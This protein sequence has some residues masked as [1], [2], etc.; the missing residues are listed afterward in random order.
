M[1]L[2]GTRDGKFIVKKLNVQDKI[3]V[4][5][6][7]PKTVAYS[8]GAI[9]TGE[10]VNANGTAAYDN[11]SIL[12]Q[13]PYAMRLLVTPGAAGTAANTDALT[14]VGIDAMGIRRE[15]DIIISSTA[16]TATPSTYAYAKITSMTPN[17]VSKCTD[18]GIGYDNAVIGLPHPIASSGDIVSF[19][20]DGG[21]ST[22]LAADN[23][24]TVEPT[25]DTM[26]LTGTAA[27]KVVQVTYK[28][29][30]QE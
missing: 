20:Y 23:A 11:T 13:P 28:S 10:D 14:V 1:G 30:M 6:V 19:A 15:E 25:Y 17:A 24:F 21:Y 29:K 8:T 3:P 22:T 12:V 2:Y 5:Y 16:A 4:Q 7:I 27:G 18:L 9:M 26:T